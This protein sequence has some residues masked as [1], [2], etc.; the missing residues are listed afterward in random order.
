MVK[1]DELLSTFG[2]FPL[3]LRIGPTH[4]LVVFTPNT[5]KV[6]PELQLGVNSCFRTPSAPLP[7]L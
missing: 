6:F 3:P 4:A 5:K 2:R 1:V 7:V